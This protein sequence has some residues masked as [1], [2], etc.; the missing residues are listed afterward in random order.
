MQKTVLV[1]GS[2]GRFG[3]HAAEAF[4]NAGWTVRLFDRARDDLME[5]AQGADIIVAASNPPYYLWKTHLLC[6]HAEIQTVA[7][8]TGA[9]VLLPGNVYVFGPHAP[10]PW[11]EDTPRTAQNP[12]GKIRV[13]LEQSYRDSGVQ[14]ILLRA[15]DFID[16]EASGGWFDKVLM[17]QV[18]RGQLLYPGDTDALHSWAFLPDLA[19]AAEQIARRKQ[20]LAQF[21]EVVFPG[22]TATATQIANQLSQVLGKCLT[23]RRMSWMPLRLAAPFWRLS[24]GLIEMRYLWDLPHSLHSDRLAKL[25]PDYRDT[26]MEEALTRIAAPLLTQALSQRCGPCYFTRRSTQTSL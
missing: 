11:S 18:R 4:W 22:Y 12:L 3:R 13:G 14:T 1:L 8:A 10:T 17:S 25:C 2:T 21:E 23:A 5:M 16:T 6:M 24:Q 7:R 15:G 20:S 9:A 26:P 19:R